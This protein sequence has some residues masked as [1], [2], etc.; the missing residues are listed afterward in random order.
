[1]MC[2][3]LYVRRWSPCL[4][5][6][7]TKPSVNQRKQNRLKTNPSR[8]VRT[9]KRSERKKNEKFITVFLWLYDRFDLICN[10]LSLN[11]W[12][13]LSLLVKRDCRFPYQKSGGA[14]KLD[15]QNIALVQFY[16]TVTV[17]ERGQEKIVQT[18]ET[19]SVGFF[20]GPFTAASAFRQFF[21]QLSKYTGHVW[22]IVQPKNETWLFYFSLVHGYLKNWYSKVNSGVCNFYSNL[23]VQFS[24]KVLQNCY[25]VAFQMTEVM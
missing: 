10:Y 25:I 4:S 20:N 17:R 8:T 21:V 3:L 12:W 9:G 18:I 15:G 11:L 6:I 7:V 2:F 24:F 23:E 13:K 5:A 14:N 1:M 22:N 16:C 19:E